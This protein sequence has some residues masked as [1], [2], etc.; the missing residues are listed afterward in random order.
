MVASRTVSDLPDWIVAAQAL[1]LAFALVREDPLQDQALV[2]QLAEEGRAEL[3]VLQIASGGCTAALLAREPAVARLRLVDANPAQLGLARLKLGL[4][5]EEPRARRRLLGHDP[6]E[7]AERAEG[8]AA[9]AKRCEVDLGVL[10]PSQRLA[11]WGPDRCGRYEE[12][13][14]ALRRSLG[15]PARVEQLLL[16]EVSTAE[17]TTL[18][19]ELEPELARA[20]AEVFALPGLIALFGAAA[21]ANRVQPFSAHFHQRTL[22]ALRDASLPARE[23]P[24]LWSVLLGRFPPEVVLP[25]LELPAAEA[26]AE[27]EFEQAF[28]ADGLE[29]AEGPFDYVHLSNVLDWLD[30]ATAAETLARACAK[31]RPGGL[32]SVRQLNSTL[33]VRAAAPAELRWEEERSAELGALDRS[34]FYRELHV[35]RRV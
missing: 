30:P 10:G 14:A 31:L 28:V 19:A 16:A 2:R 32:L 29:R 3:A 33:D 24:Y 15:D 13:F 20:F 12:T 18:L 4:L 6:C 8:L 1:P 17:Q 5:S 25:W 27:V 35:G 23:N 9:L 22:H 34:Y 11:E 26:A 7:A 21:T